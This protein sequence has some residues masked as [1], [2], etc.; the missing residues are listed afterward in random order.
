[1]ATDGSVII[2]TRLST[3]NLQRDV[4]NVNNQL[5]NI[6]SNMN[7]VG[8]RMN[9]TMSQQMNY[10]ANQVTRH[11]R[12]MSAE[13]QAMA[14]EM[15]EAYRAQSR[16]MLQYEEQLLG[17]E[18]AFFRAAQA[19]GEYQG[20]NQQFMNSLQELGNT[21]RQINDQMMASNQLALA[22]IYSSVAALMAMSTQASKI[23]ANYRR[24]ANPIY[25]VN[26]GLL[27]MADNLN[28]A[29]NAAQPAALALRM[30]GPNANMKQLND[31]IN[32][33]NQGLMRHQMITLGAAIAS[34]IF[35]KQLH[36]GAMATNKAYKTAFEEMGEA[37]RKAFQ[38]MVD[39]FAMVMIPV[40]KFITAIAELV[41]QFNEAHPTVAKLVAAFLMLIPALTLLLSPLAIGIGLLGGMQAAFGALWAIIGPVVTGL[42]AM[43]G[44]VLLVSAAIVG[45][46]YGIITL[47]KNSETFRNG[48]YTVIAALQTFGQAIV[49]FGKYLFYVITTGDTMND[50]LTHLP[51][52]FQGVA[53]A[54]GESINSIINF[55]T[56]FGKYIYWVIASGDTMNDWLSHLPVVFQ[57][58]AYGIG[59]GIVKIKEFLNQFV[60]A[61]K[62]AF[63]GDFTQLTQ[64]FATLIP[65]IIGLL[66]GG[67]PALLL[68]VAR[69]MPAI[70]EQLNMGTE[71]IVSVINSVINAIVTFLTTQVPIFL[72]K[73]V[74]I[75]TSIIQGLI[76]ALPVVVQAISNI[77][78]ALVEVITTS[79][80]MLLE[81]GV[82]IITALVEGILT[83]L[84]SLLNVG[85]ELIVT[86]VQGIIQVLPQLVETATQIIDTVLKT[87]TQLLP[88]LL[89][90][91]VDVLM[92]LVEGILEVIPD[93]IETAT[94]IISTLLETI[95]QMLPEVLSAGTD[96]LLALIDGILDTL[97]QL[98]DTALEIVINI[99]DI[100]VE[101]LP[102]LIEAGVKILTSLIEGIINIIPKLIETAVL[103]ITKILE[104]LVSNLP[105]IIEA[106]VKILLA[107]ISGIIQI[108]PELIKA[109]IKLAVTIVNTI[110]ENLPKILNSGKEILKALVEG[111]VSLISML[112]KAIKTDIMDG[113]KSAISD[114]IKDITTVGKDIIN[115]LI[116]GIT[117]MGKD[118]I[119]AI[120]GVVGGVISAAKKMLDSH[121]PSRVFIGIGND[122]IDGFD[123]GLEER[124]KRLEGTMT[125]I[126][127]GL[128]T[129][130]KEHAKEELELSKQKNAQ[131]AEVEKRAKE[132]IDKIY[133]NAY[134]KK[135][136]TTIDE[137]IKIQRIQ[138]DSAKKVAD[139]EKKSAVESEKI[140]KEA[141]QAKLESV[142]NFIAAKKE[143]EGLSLIDEA[144]IWEQSLSLFKA[145]SKERL[146]AQKEYQS[147]VAAVNQELT[148]INKEYSTEIQKVHDDLIKSEESVNKAVE[149]SIT[150]RENFYKNSKGIFDEFKVELNRTGEE[151][152]N[153]LS[154]QIVHF[155]GWQREIEHLATRAIDEGL[156]AE[157][158][159]MGPAALAEIVALNSMT[160]V[161]LTKYSEMYRAKAKW[162]REMAVKEHIDMKND[163]DKQ[164]KEMRSSADKQLDNLNREWDSKIKGLTKAT[165]SELSTLKQIGQAAGQGLLDGISSVEQPL[166]NKLNE[167]SN[168]IK[169]V[170]GEA[171][172]V[173]IPINTAPKYVPPSSGGNIS[174]SAFN[175][176][177]KPS[178]NTVSNGVKS[179]LGAVSKVV[180]NK[181]DQGVTQ[182]LNFT[183]K[184]MSPY[185]IARQTK[186]AAEQAAL[187]W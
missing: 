148:A 83:L 82:T 4:Q 115:G 40:Y 85:L 141:Q 109:I 54:I 142:K 153:N 26:Q 136:K 81:S 118:A 27:T 53:L 22:G 16:S 10:M 20:T 119:E 179:A 186:K 76:S 73:G 12:Y 157:L 184:P 162:A 9:R 150:K 152:L 63:Q 185:E 126:T 160:D 156:L 32:M 35:Y 45:L 110:V 95:V 50:W 121:S 42:A 138:E 13:A 169:R 176:A 180:N 61:I 163:A 91:G 97:P 84:P 1:M 64:V 3:G 154:S 65:T 90:M 178:N 37:V 174:S 129:I 23:S 171:L 159:E 55:F 19:S 107:I 106:G 112:L 68:T 123:I 127:K 128:V 38:P 69:F 67:L 182:H 158:R 111:I 21:Q 66:I 57:N 96:L 145:N 98:I 140:Q 177:S 58:V 166:Y 102:K 31:M 72:Q 80:P 88:K 125:S 89:K 36:D 18:Y 105:K 100:I 28:R 104:T 149:D 139:I 30:L 43:M 146:A 164:I 60:E 132:D 34:A 101:N 99:I 25:N 71:T 155:E 114:K 62:A 124:R 181:Y 92:K 56:S 46:T 133:R 120:T 147:A 144:Y 11:S 47:W 8:T 17:I 131:I 116:E 87:L 183:T 2:D 187:G 130:G 122:T 6:G 173:D 175:A 75:L 49:D 137:N 134:A 151:L 161:Q 52:G 79:L 14:R 170:M 135:R 70:A 29:A 167:I 172:N 103:L 51:A 24:M 39:V 168:N 41:I 113:I 74:E 15:S 143:I 108:L 93:L 94:D 117:S 44:T 5:G 78:A 48:V 33:I 77:I 86:L 7:D 59:E 165:K